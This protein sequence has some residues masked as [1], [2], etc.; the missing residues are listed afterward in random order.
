[1]EQ[2]DLAVEMEKH[3]ERKKNWRRKSIDGYKQCISTG[4]PWSVYEF[5]NILLENC[6]RNELKT[7]FL[8]RFS[9][10]KEH[11]IPTDSKHLLYISRIRKKITGM[12]GSSFARRSNQIES[13][14]Q[15]DIMKTT[16]LVSFG[17]VSICCC[18]LKEQM[19]ST[20]INEIVFCANIFRFMK[21]TSLFIKSYIKLV[22]SNRY[23]R[24]FFFRLY[25][26]SIGIDSRDKWE[27]EWLR[28]CKRF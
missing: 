1:M 4:W 22:H 24:G 16:V 23:F 10:H 19:L 21:T 25:K 27:S 7:T 14:V 15:I 12:N 28:L 6:L 26:R 13:S 3:W 18:N 11:A 8:L 2:S 5:E 9:V 17:I 20:P